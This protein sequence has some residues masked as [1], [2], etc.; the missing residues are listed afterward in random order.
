MDTKNNIEVREFQGVVY[1]KLLNNKKIL[2]CM[3]ELAH[4]SLGFWIAECRVVGKVP[5]DDNL[6]GFYHEMH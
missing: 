6:T 1:E 5:N 2:I 3:K 4:V